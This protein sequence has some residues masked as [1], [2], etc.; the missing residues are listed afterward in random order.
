[1]NAIMTRSRT[2]DRRLTA[3]A[4]LL[5]VGWWSKSLLTSRVRAVT[6]TNR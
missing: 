5:G 6:I 2:T 4:R 3:G 1:M